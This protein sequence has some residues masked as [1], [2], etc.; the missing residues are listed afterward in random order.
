MTEESKVRRKRRPN[1]D[2]ALDAAR[3]LERGQELV[4][5]ITTL[6]DGLALGEL[7]RLCGMLPSS[8]PGTANYIHAHLAQTGKNAP[9]PPTL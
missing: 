2:L 5:F 8:S 6:I 9:L 3:R 1:L 7:D 4:V